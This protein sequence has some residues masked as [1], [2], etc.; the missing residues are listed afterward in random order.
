M[1]DESHAVWG[2]LI[3][4]ELMAMDTSRPTATDSTPKTSLP[5]GHKS[6]SVPQN[7]FKAEA[8]DSEDLI[9]LCNLVNDG[10][11]PADGMCFAYSTVK[12]I[13]ACAASSQYLR[14]VL[15]VRHSSAATTL[16][17][18]YVQAVW[19]LWALT[20]ASREELE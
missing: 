19:R 7:I 4:P 5:L 14:E 20:L 13:E 6:A 1:L 18:Q 12:L 11:I 3:D 8:D 2:G 16:S 10:Y 9:R 17:N 15:E